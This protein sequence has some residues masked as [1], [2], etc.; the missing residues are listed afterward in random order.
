MTTAQVIAK[1]GPIETWDTSRVTKMNSV[2]ARKKNI[3]PDIRNWI[4]N[5]VTSMKSMFY[6]ADS[7]N[8]DLSGWIVSSVTNMDWMFNNAAAYTQVLCGN[9]WVESTAT[10]SIMFHAAGSNAKIGNLVQQ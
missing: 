3:N 7:F 5:S 4:V 6:E 8:I 10:K 9:T 2:S 1:H